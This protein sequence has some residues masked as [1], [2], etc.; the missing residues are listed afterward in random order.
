MSDS[1]ALARQRAECPLGLANGEA[2]PEVQWV[3]HR[4]VGERIAAG[5]T[6]ITYFERH[7]HDDF[8]VL[9]Q[10]PEAGAKPQETI[11]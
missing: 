11:K 1:G 6:M 3:D 8:A 5:W 4:R 10:A 2:A 9:M 7:H